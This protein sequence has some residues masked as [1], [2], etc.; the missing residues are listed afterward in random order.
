MTPQTLG[1]W[2]WKYR[3]DDEEEMLWIPWDDNLPLNWRVQCLHDPAP[4]PGPFLVAIIDWLCA[5][6]HFPGRVR[7]L[8]DVEFVFALTLDPDFE[9]PLSS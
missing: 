1:L 9:F 5:A 7:V 3:P 2:R 4:V 6:A 8:N